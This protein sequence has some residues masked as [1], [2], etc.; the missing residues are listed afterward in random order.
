MDISLLYAAGLASY[1]E[2]HSSLHAYCQQHCGSLEVMY[3]ARSLLLCIPVV[4]SCIKG[5]H[6]CVWLLF[7]VTCFWYSSCEG[8]AVAWGPSR[9]ASSGAGLPSHAFS[10]ALL[11]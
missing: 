6:V 10:P 7:L 2:M 1:D 5:A 8:R 9:V 11:T 4:P 3:G